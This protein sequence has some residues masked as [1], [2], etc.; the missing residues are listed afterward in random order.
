MRKNHLKRFLFSLLMFLCWVSIIICVTAYVFL[1][2]TWGARLAST[3]LIE[4]F[5]PS[6]NISVGSYEGTIEKGLLFKGV[7]ISH[8]P[9]LKNGI[10]RIQDLSI[11][12]PLIHWDQTSLRIN[13]ATLFLPLSDPIIFHGT[14]IQN[15]IKGACYAHGVDAKQVVSSLGYDELAKNIYGSISNVDLVVEGPVNSPRLTG[16]FLVDKFAFKNTQ[17]SDGF[18]HLDLTINSLGAVP[19]M[20]GFIIMESALVKVEKV[21]IDLATSKVNFKGDVSDFLLDIHGSS[22]VEDIAIDLAIKGTF[23]KPKLVFNSDPPMSEE[24]IM[25]ALATGKSWSGIDSSQGIGLRK[26]LTDTF[27]VGMEVEERQSQLGKDRTQAYSRTLEGQMNVTDKFSLNVARKFLPVDSESSSSG[28]GSSQ[29]QKD[30]ES[31]IYL[32]YK[33]RF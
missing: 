7:T 10:I 29:P 21:L 6:C 32:Q 14:V 18:S 25:I 15:K 2:T 8:I 11:Q 33:Q 5:I 13:N 9:N 12:V 26:K 20:T 28:V 24:Q 4:S 17:L 27:N 19:S 1:T 16:S 31:E 22:K 3:C 23:Q 30:N